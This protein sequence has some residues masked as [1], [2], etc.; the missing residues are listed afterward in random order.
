MHI[1]KHKVL[2]DSIKI[3]IITNWLSKYF[4]L[5]LI[6]HSVSLGIYARWH[7]GILGHNFLSGATLS[8]GKS[9]ANLN[10]SHS[11]CFKHLKT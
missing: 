8:T 4:F 2:G 10:F 6:G 3:S 9:E 1:V 5:N 7:L 11:V